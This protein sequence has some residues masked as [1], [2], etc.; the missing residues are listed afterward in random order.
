[1]TLSGGNEAALSAAFFVHAGAFTEM[2][3]VDENTLHC[4][5]NRGIEAQEARYW[6]CL[7][8]TPG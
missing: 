3:I 8:S 4:W 1:M 6:K 2:K 5:I 7:L